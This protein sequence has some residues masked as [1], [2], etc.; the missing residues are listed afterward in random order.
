MPWEVAGVD[1]F[2]VKNKHLCIVDYYSKFP[3]VKKT[4]AVSLSA[5]DLVRAA[6]IV[7]NE[8]ELPKKIISYVGMNFTSQKFRQFCRKMNIEQAIT[9]FPHYQSSG[10]CR[11]VQNA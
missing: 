6:K 8:F 11:Y 5:D 7:F 9:S 1:I 4:K 2:F 10:Q 3:L